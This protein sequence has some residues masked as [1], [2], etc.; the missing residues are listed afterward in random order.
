MVLRRKLDR[1]KL[2]VLLD[3]CAIA[4]LPPMYFFSHVYYTDVPSMTTILFLVYF[5]MKEYYFVSSIFGFFSVLM[6]QTNIVWVAGLF[7]ALALEC[8]IKKVYPKV[9]LDKSTFSQLMF[10]S[11][12]TLIKPR[13]LISLMIEIVKKFYGYIAVVVSF[14][15]FLYIN[16]SIVGMLINH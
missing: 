4:I 5:S 1:G 9:N 2:N 16:G 11:K 13:I 6:R 12:S 8:M 3:S 7:G 10:A 14:I 15:V